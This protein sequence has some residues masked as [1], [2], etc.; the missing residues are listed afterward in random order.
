MDAKHSRIIVAI[1]FVLV[2]RK[3]LKIYISVGG[4]LELE[5]YVFI[6]VFKFSFYSKRIE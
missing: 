5:I 3:K 2:E 1:I 6:K 4:C